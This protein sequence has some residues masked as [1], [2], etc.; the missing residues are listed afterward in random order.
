MN[1]AEREKHLARMIATRR[2]MD[3]HSETVFQAMDEKYRSS[4][5]GPLAVEVSFMPNENGIIPAFHDP[6]TFRIV[7][8][9]DYISGQDKPEWLR[10]DGVWESCFYKIKYML[11]KGRNS[12]GALVICHADCIFVDGEIMTKYRNAGNQVP[13]SS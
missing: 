1:K 9:R 2:F 12:Y 3:Q 5:V 6:P 8:F 7:R 13:F 11:E 4:G 10:T